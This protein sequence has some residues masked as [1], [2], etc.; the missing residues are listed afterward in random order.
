MP[1][2]GYCVRCKS[3]KPMKNAMV[4]TTNN[5]RKVLKGQ[6]VCGCRMTKFVA[7]DYTVDDE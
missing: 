7:N 2:T 3:S 1:Q 6:C 5:D 4:C